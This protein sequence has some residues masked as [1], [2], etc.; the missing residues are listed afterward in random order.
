MP[1]S[2]VPVPAARVPRRPKKSRESELQAELAKA[3]R[4]IAQL[5]QAV[6]ALR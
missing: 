1:E 2:P 5:E 4:Y 3:R 6:R